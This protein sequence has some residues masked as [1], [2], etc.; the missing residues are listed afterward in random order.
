VPPVDLDG[1]SFTLTLTEFKESLPHEGK[2]IEVLFMALSTDARHNGM[3]H[4]GPDNYTDDEI[5]RPR[6]EHHSRHRSRQ[7]P[8]RYVLS[9]L[10]P[11][12]QSPSAHRAL[13]WFAV[14]R[15][16]GTKQVQ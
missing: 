10:N 11:V 13:K 7:A 8:A 1:I 15:L 6:S 9:Y 16:A 14:F 12:S 5:R 2:H 3:L 4:L